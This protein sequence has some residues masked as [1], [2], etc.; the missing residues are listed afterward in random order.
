MEVREEEGEEGELR[1]LETGRVRGHHAR[2][3]P[4]VE[5]GDGAA[6]ELPAA[7]QVAQNDGH[8]D[9]CRARGNRAP[10]RGSNR[11]SQPS[12]S[13]FGDVVADGERG[14]GGERE[15][16]R[17]GQVVGHS[18]RNARCAND[19]RHHELTVVVVVQ[20]A[21]GKPRVQRRH[22]GGAEDGVQVREVHGLFAAQ[23]GVPQVGVC[24][25]HEH[26]GQERCEEEGLLRQ[27]GV[28]S[29]GAQS[30]AG[31]RGER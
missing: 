11:A 7:V 16:E 22:G 31:S 18:R 25:A 2:G 26:E 6:Q 1:D 21:A 5:V 4:E 8:R 24:G 29:A 30:S 14:A 3:R 19:R 13:A 15:E 20:G 9:G 17:H 28:A 27:A 10:P 23:V 12:P